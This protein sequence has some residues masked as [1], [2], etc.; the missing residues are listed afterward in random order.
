MR[1]R[2]D[3]TTTPCGENLHETNRKDRP[4]FRRTRRRARFPARS[5]FLAAYLSWSSSDV[6][7][8]RRLTKG[9]HQRDSN[10]LRSGMRHGILLSPFK[11]T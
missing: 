9:R 10:D 5:E 8:L 4:T 1:G 11:L 7:C 3:R 2:W 6:E